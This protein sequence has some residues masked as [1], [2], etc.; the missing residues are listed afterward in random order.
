MFR[1][2]GEI[3]NIN[4]GENNTN[5][6]INT[7]DQKGGYSAPHYTFYRR[8]IL[9]IKYDKT[10]LAIEIIATLLIFLIAFVTYLF[11]YEVNFNDPISKLKETFTTAQMIIIAISTIAVFLITFLAKSKEKLIKGLKIIG[12]ISLIAVFICLGIKLYLDNKYNKEMFEKFYET[13]ENPEG[14]E[15]NTSKQVITGLAK[16]ETLDEKEAY[17][18]NS[19][20]AYTNFKV[21]TTVF[22]VTQI[23][24]V[25]L[26]FYL[27]HRLSVV[28][29][30][31][32]KLY[33]ADDVLFDDEQN[34]KY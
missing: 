11:A 8:R 10:F 24:I 5:N 2:R 31:K 23:L 22:I 16:I 33:R 4:K 34:V 32:E 30:K 27:I 1:N 21:K 14:K 12:I 3:P 29:R 18:K 20:K 9:F 19:E 7:G 28:E 13:Y 15:N 17:V 6:G 26:I 25:L